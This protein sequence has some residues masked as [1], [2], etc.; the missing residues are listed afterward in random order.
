MQIVKHVPVGED[1][2]IIRKNFIFSPS[3]LTIALSMRKMDCIIYW[4]S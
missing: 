1:K 2:D 4:N 3:S